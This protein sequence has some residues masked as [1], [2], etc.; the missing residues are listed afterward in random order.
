MMLK[1]ITWII[2]KLEKRLSKKEK[3]LFKKETKNEKLKLYRTLLNEIDS[4]NSKTKNITTLRHY[5][6]ITFGIDDLESKGE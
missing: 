2:G 3:C 5:R 1:I 4:Y 6:Y